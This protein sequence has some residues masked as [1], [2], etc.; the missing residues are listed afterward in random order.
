M[1]KLNFY[2][3]LLLSFALPLASL[4]SYAGNIYHFI[5]KNGVATLSK[6]LPPYA[7]Q[8][9]YEV[10]DEKTLRVVERVLTQSETIEQHNAEQ[11]IAQE[12][13]LQQEKLEQQQRLQQEQRTFD[14]NLL[15][16][17]PSV[18]DLIKTRDEQLADINK[19]I[20]NSLAQQSVI[21]KNLLQLQQSAAEQEL[22]GQSVS[23]E[24]N[25]R[26]ETT[27]QEVVD[28]QL[29]LNSLRSD[30]IKSS[31]QYENELIRLRQLRNIPQETN[32]Q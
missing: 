32:T 29:H 18:Q 19:Q 9:G 4:P 27:Q 23:S 13:Q 20:F 5:D 24:L 14:Q 28:N 26:I 16:V 30:N 2:P 15:E 7:A 25:Q 12:K 22:S 21:Q 3:A 31:Q 10:L 6:T 17:Y 1:K 11:V 8:Q